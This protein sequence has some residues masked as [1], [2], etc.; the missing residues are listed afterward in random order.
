MTVPEQAK[1]LDGKRVAEICKRTL[2]GR[3]DAHLLEKIREAF[4]QYPIRL[5]RTGHEWY[6][7]GGIVGRDGR[8]IAN[9]LIEWAERSH[10]ECGQNLRTLIDHVL[11]QQLIVTRHKGITLYVIAQTGER[12]EDFVQIEIDKT[13]EVSDHLLINPD[14][15]PEDL[16]DLIDPLEPEC[17]ETFDIGASRYAYRR[18]TE[19]RRFMEELSFHHL[20]KHPAQRFMDDWNRSSANRKT[21]FSNDWLLRPYQ[22][23]GRFGEQ[24]MNVE[25]VNIQEKKLPHMEEI[26]GKKGNGLNGLLARFDRQAGYPFAWFFYMVKGMFVSPHAGEAVHQDLRGDFAYLPARDAEVLQEWID[27]PYSV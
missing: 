4:P 10:I 21:L 19:V 26:A 11:E 16:Q 8:R 20:D 3:D 5:A 25:V 1:Q 17:I 9:D 23:I 22:H 15:P 12:A 7:I 2:P 13:Q 27:R 6:R 14:K 18:K 24:L